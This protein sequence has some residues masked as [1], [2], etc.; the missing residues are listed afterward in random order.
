MN[1][2]DDDWGTIREALKFLPKA[3]ISSETK[4]PFKPIATDA[5]RRL[6]RRYRLLTSLAVAAE[7]MLEHPGSPVHADRFRVALA[8]CGLQQ[9][10]VKAS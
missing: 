7:E 10:E 2:S 9:P 8:Q 6:E 5:T 1:D 4:E 3:L